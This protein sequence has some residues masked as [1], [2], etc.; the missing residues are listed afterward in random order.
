MKVFVT[1]GTGAIGGH[2]V[3]ALVEAGHSVTALARTVDKAMILERQGA[4]PVEVSLFDKAR[5]TE[6]FSGHDAVINLATAL[7]ATKDFRKISAWSENIRIRSEGS[8]CIVDAALDAGVPRLIQESVSMIYKDHGSNWIDET[9]STDNFPTAQ[10]N[11][12]AEASANRFSG[13]GGTGIILR[14][15]WFYGPGAKHSEEFLALARNWGICIMMGRAATYLSSIHVADGGRA[16]AAALAAPAG[17]Y[18]VVDDMPLSKQDFADAIA[19]AAGR[20]IYLRA[21]GR[22]ANFLGDDTTSLTRSLRVSNSVFREVTGWK[23]QFPS[24]REGWSAMAAGLWP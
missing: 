6:V 11:L 13:S 9:G 5:L 21:P 4:T 16:V 18:N 12:A 3:S 15:G 7:P 2:A 20:K 14:L 19:A 24:A 8:A 1:G 22:I 10:S 23:P 17:T